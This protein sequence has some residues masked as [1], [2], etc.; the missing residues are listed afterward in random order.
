MAND[1]EETGSSATEA[2]IAVHWREEEYFY[3]L[4]PLLDRPTHRTR[5]Y[6]SGSP[7][8]V[9]RMLPGVRR[10]ARLGPVLAHNAR[11]ERPAVLEVVR[12]RSPKRHLQLY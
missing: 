6:S 8:R 7:R 3:P 1:N 12:G 10:T 4:P 9:S 5:R 11:H 2:Q